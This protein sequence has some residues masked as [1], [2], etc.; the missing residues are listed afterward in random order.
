MK[1]KIKGVVNVSRESKKILP[2]TFGLV[3]FAP[4]TGNLFLDIFVDTANQPTPICRFFDGKFVRLAEPASKPYFYVAKVTQAT[5]NQSLRQV[6]TE[7]LV[8]KG[9]ADNYSFK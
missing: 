5:T 2:F 8:K 7:A 1:I 4:I 9:I 3:G 6:V